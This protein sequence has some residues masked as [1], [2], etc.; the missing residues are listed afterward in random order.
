M[1][2]LVRVYNILTSIHL[3]FH[4]KQDGSTA[5]IYAA[6]KGHSDVV[7]LLVEAHA[8][9]NLPDEVMTFYITHSHVSSS[10]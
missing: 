10:N 7:S 2:Q 5:L 9:I 6:E 1:K 4:F 3:I 8:D